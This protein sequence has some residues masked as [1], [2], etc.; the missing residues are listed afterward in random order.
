MA[1]IATVGAVSAA[2]LGFGGSPAL[3]FG[4]EE[5]EEVAQ[6]IEQCL[7]EAEAGPALINLN[8]NLN[9]LAQCLANA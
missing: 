9:L 7:Q 3:A 4:H 6:T 8:L 2:L 1:K 5:E